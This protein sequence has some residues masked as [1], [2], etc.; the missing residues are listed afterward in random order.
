MKQKKFKIG[1]I[2]SQRYENKR[3]IREII[4]KLHK[5]FNEELIIVSGGNPTGAEKYIKKYAL[6]I[7]CNYREFNPSHTTRN[8]YSALHEG[9]Y[10]KPY[11]P[12]NFFHRNKLIAKDVNSLI[13]FME[14]M[15]DA[16]GVLDIIN[17]VKRMN[18]KVI[19]IN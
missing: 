6:E 1:I 3:K 14:N 13:V 17:N 16:T 15:K 18:K 19:I 8:L 12:A 4:F 2:G 9:F 11:K 5:K 7:G 10:N